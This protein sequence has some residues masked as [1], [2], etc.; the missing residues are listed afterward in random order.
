M[1]P[2]PDEL[3]LLRDGGAAAED[4][5]AAIGFLTSFNSGSAAAGLDDVALDLGSS[6]VLALFQMELGPG[7]LAAGLGSDAFAK[8]EDGVAA[9]A[10]AAA[11]AIGPWP[12]R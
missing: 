10:E 4:D 5:A 3:A 11:A 2:P 8:T 1:P 6:F 12:L 9:G 7:A